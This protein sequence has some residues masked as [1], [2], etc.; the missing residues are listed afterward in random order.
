MADAVSNTQEAEQT[1]TAQQ[2]PPK[3]EAPKNVAPA[4]PQQQ[5]EETPATTAAKKKKDAPQAP[6]NQTQ[7][8]PE[9]EQT[10]PKQS[11]FVGGLQRKDI[12]TLHNVWNS[13]NID[14]NLE[15]TM[16]EGGEIKKTRSGL[17]FK[18]DNGHKIVWTPNHTMRGQKIPQEFIGISK[19]KGG[20][21]DK[22]AKAIV[23]LAKMR[24]W[25]SIELHGTLKEKDNM[26]L[27]AQRQ[28]LPVKG[29]EPSAEMKAKWEAEKIPGHDTGATQAQKRRAPQKDAGVTNADKAPAQSRYAGNKRK[30]ANSQPAKP[31]KPEGKGVA[32]SKI[33]NMR[34]PQA[35]QD[36]GAPKNDAPK[37]DAPANAQP[38]KP[39]Q[40]AGQKRSSKQGPKM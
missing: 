31:E 27:E 16:R 1:D 39:A 26:W 4:E 29:Y 10:A 40:P 11:I 23:A 35:V 30:P 37:N 13:P 3:T 2:T 22:D 28:G 6:V 21:D 5:E 7:A 34:K 15:E 33:A 9:V 24:G 8:E 25:K 19:H 12:D 17:N 14:P 20:I 32:G 38:A 36:T 18:L